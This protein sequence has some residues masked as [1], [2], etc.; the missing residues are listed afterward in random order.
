QTPPRSRFPIRRNFNSLGN[1]F[2]TVAIN[3]RKYQVPRPERSFEKRHPRLERE[4]VIVIVVE[5]GDVDREAR[6]QQVAVSGFVAQQRFGSK[7][8]IARGAEK[9]REIGVPQSGELE[10]I[11]EV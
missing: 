11:L 6:M 7:R 2:Q 8:S 10:R 1:T 9:R 5:G 4:Q 3:R